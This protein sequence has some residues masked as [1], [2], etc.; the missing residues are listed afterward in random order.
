M[1][2]N[3]LLD[4]RSAFAS[5][6]VDCGEFPPNRKIEDHPTSFADVELSHY[7]NAWNGSDCVE[8]SGPRSSNTFRRLRK[9]ALPNDI[10]VAEKW[11]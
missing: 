5:Y 3:S 1:W 6:N 2:L 9:G 7:Q 11:V 8:F 4:C 10:I